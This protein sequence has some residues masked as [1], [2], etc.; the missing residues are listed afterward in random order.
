[1]SDTLEEIRQL[2][3]QEQYKEA[4]EK[5]FTLQ[6]DSER[7]EASFLLSKA[8]VEKGWLET[9]TDFALKAYE[10]EPDHE[11]YSA[12]YSE[13]VGQRGN[14]STDESEKKSG[15]CS[16]LNI[17]ECCECMGDCVD[18]ANCLESCP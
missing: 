2:I 5:L 11:E 8:Y 4:E 17:C 15:C 10:A 14:Y 3:E 6:D 1:M 16:G 18:C 9:A 7:A 13:I 12:W